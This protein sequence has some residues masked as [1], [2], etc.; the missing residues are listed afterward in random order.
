MSIAIRQHCP[1][2]DEPEEEHLSVTGLDSKVVKCTTCN[3][4]YEVNLRYEFL[5]YEVSRICEGCEENEEN[6][7][8]DTIASEPS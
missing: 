3:K 6:C 4:L 7:W 2:C 8:C 1:Y 5:G